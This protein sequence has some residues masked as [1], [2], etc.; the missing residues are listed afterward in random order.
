[1]KAVVGLFIFFT[2]VIYVQFIN[3][4]WNVDG[5]I[6]DFIDA[7]SIIMIVLSVLSVSIITGN[8]K[9]FRVGIEVLFKNKNNNKKD[10]ECALALYTLL[11]KVIFS[12]GF[13]SF[14]SNIIAITSFRINY[15]Y[16]DDMSLIL[17]AL[18]VAM[19]GIYYA[20]IVNIIF[21]FPIIVLLKKQLTEV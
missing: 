9:D 10:N 5:A 3:A 16:I 8:F 4:G 1:M 2:G 17:N 15:L 14:F 13:I 19:L 12:A 20:L 11:F 18:S 6:V 7:P 21:I